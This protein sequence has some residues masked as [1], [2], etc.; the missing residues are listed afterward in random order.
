MVVIGNNMYPLDP[1]GRSARPIS[2]EGDSVKKTALRSATVARVVAVGLALT[3]CTNGAGAPAADG[4][5]GIDFWG[6]AP[7]YAEA[8]DAYNASQD[9]VVVDYEE[10]SPSAKGGCEKMLNAV[11]AGDAPCLGQVGETLHGFAAQ[12]TLEASPSAQATTRR[13]RRPPRGVR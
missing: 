3:A 10:V 9:A 6:S 1:G 2:F 8:V 13:V 12:G 7:G 4:P 5:V 11:T